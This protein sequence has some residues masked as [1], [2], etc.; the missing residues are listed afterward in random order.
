MVITTDVHLVGTDWTTVIDEL[1]PYFTKQTNYDLFILASSIGIMYDKRID[2]PEKKED[3]EIKYVP[4]NVLQNR[5]KEPG[6]MLDLLFQTAIL[7]SR[8]IDYE[9]KERMDL[10]FGEGKEFNRLAFLTEFANFGAKKLVE[11]IG[12][13]PAET[14][15]N[16][17]VFL[18][19]SFE[20]R[21]FEIDELDE[22]MLGDDFEPETNG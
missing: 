2:S 6:C 5:N 8:T 4:R 18:V 11:L 7:S 10:A 15:N 19:S 13:A 21:N 9:E 14:M 22:D 3:D 17:N 20:G 1:A 16:I 12:S